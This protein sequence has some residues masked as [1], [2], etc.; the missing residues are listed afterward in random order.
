[1]SQRRIFQN[2]FPY[3]VTFNVFNG[4]Y[5][6]ED[7]SLAVW[8]SK[9]IFLSAQIKNYTVLAFQIMPNHVHLLIHKRTLEKVRLKTNIHIS[10][11]P[12]RMLSSVRSHNTGKPTI[13]DLMQSIKGNFSKKYQLNIWQRRF[14]TKIINT[15]TYLET[16]I[17]YIKYNPVKTHLPSRYHKPP[18][19]YF[20]WE[21]IGKLF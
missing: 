10:P 11:T 19:Q 12:E 9:E 21:E 20:N 8:L 16:I 3:F 1:M 7:R 15:H 14:Y 18:Y 13:S 5:F 2:E 4:F 6:F 17:E